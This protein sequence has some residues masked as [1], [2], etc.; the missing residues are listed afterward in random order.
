MIM[1]E[2]GHFYNEYDA[3][4]LYSISKIMLSKPY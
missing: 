4:N 1:L 3:I 2:E